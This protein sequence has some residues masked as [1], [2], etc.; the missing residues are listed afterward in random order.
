MCQPGEVGHTIERFGGAG[1]ALSGPDASSEIIQRE[2][3]S[4]GWPG[5]RQDQITGC[6]PSKTARHHPSSGDRRHFYWRPFVTHHL[7]L[8][9]FQLTRTLL[10]ERKGLRFNNFPVRVEGNILEMLSHQARDVHLLLSLP[11]SLEE[12]VTFRSSLFSRIFQHS[13][14]RILTGDTIFADLP[15][16]STCFLPPLLT[17][18]SFSSGVLILLSG[19]APVPAPS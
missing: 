19:H 10:G 17:R 7:S 14:G 8:V 6:H 2:A 12:L 5:G 15:Q 4:S 18:T 13:L 9:L 11:E 1:E 3:R 16:N